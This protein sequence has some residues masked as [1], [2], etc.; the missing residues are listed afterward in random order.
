METWIEWLKKKGYDVEKYK[1]VNFY[2]VSVLKKW[3]K[4]GEITSEM[5]MF[6]VKPDYLP[7][8]L[9]IKGGKNE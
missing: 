7:K 1:Y 9:K 2:P 6:L 8:E 3:W 5:L 4:K